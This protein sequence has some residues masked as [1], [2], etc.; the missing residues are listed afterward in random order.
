M[1]IDLEK[2]PYYFEA[3]FYAMTTHSLGSVIKWVMTYMLYV[4][5]LVTFGTNEK[6]RWCI[7]KASTAEH[8]GCF[9]LTEMYHGSFNRGMRSEARYDHASK[10]FTITTNE[11]EGQKFW[12]GGAA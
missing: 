6:A 11:K 10:T 4:K 3:V 8:I 7:E 1:K 5:A 12:I 2:D 9:A